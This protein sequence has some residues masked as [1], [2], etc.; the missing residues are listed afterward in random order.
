[1]CAPWH[2]EVILG[3][4]R[5]W[6]LRPCEWTNPDRR[7]WHGPFTLSCFSPGWG[8]SLP[9]SCPLPSATRRDA[10]RQLA[11]WWCFDL[12][13]WDVQNC[14]DVFL[15]YKF[16]CLRCSLTAAQNRP[17]RWTCGSVFLACALLVTPAQYLEA[18]FPSAR[19]SLEDRLSR[20][21]AFP[22][23]EA[24]TGSGAQGQLQLICS[25]VSLRSCSAMQTSI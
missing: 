9:L 24:G 25:V 21:S 18:C 3:L 6:W 1:M 2:Q 11:H 10:P 17:R 13:L 23:L 22:L 7:S 20:C 15:L 12:R 8:H 5:L 14:E 19:L 16:P 4:F